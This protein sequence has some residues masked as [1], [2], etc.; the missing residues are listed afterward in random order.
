M[1]V[2]D[3][4]LLDLARRGSPDAVSELYERYWPL[5]WRWAYLATGNLVDAEDVA[6][7]AICRAFRELARHDPNRP[8][9][10][11]LKRIVVNGAIDGYRREQRR[12]QWFDD[13]RPAVPE[14]DT[15]A[16][17]AVVAAVGDLPR[18]RRVVIVLHYWLGYGAEEIAQILDLPY[19]TVASR[20]SRALAHLRSILEEEHVR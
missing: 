13:L 1:T 17:D 9:G 12:S 11:W 5:A 6:Q 2:D 15:Q 19:G 18:Q 20:L 10:P 8:F 4:L 16:S 14:E 7:E 3:T